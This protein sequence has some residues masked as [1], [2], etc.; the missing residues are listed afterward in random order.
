[1]SA[2]TRLPL[3]DAFEAIASPSPVPGGGSA[4]AIAA[5][6]GVSLLRMAAGLPRT[7]IESDEDVAAV[8][9]VSSALAALQPRLTQTIDD[10]AAAYTRVAAAY[11]L[12]KGSAAEQAARQTAIQEALRAATDVPLDIMR[13][14]A[15]ALMHATRVAARGRAAVSSDIGVALDALRA[16][17][18]GAHRIVRANLAALVDHAYV[19]AVESEAASLVEQAAHSASAADAMLQR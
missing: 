13:L 9:A 7:R 2:L 3:V 1:V 5:G 8:A 4:A 12:P 6:L 15:A 19:R 18:E 16:G 14:S 11:R 17:M 10:D